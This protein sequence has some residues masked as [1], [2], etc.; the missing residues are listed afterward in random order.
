MSE[1]DMLFCDSTYQ[2]QQLSKWIYVCQGCWFNIM[3]GIHRWKDL[4]KAHLIMLEDKRREEA[5][6]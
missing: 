2:V 4:E 1:C 6:S 3:N 5:L